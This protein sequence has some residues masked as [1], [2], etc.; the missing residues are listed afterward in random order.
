MQRSELLELDGEGTGVA[1]NTDEE[2]RLPSRKPQR[3]ADA[4]ALV[5]GSGIRA[6]G[7]LRP[8]IET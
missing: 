3:C 1:E 8:V 7:I 4:I 5:H 2:G 6:D